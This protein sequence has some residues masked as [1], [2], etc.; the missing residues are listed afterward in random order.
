VVVISIDRADL[1]TDIG[2]NTLVIIIINQTMASY[3]FEEGYPGPKA[4]HSIHDTPQLLIN[5]LDGMARVRPAS[6]YGQYPISPLGYDKGLR[7]ITHGQLANA[8]NGAA[9][10]LTERLGPGKDFQTLCYMGWN[11]IRY[12]AFLLGAVKAGYKVCYF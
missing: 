2:L 3:I 5:M 8:V 7:N 10:W 6:L 11:D 1:P 9:W 4:R 12:V